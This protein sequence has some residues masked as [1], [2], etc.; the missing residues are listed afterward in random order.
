MEQ[1][2]VPAG[3]MRERIAAAV[4]TT[5]LLTCRIH[6]RAMRTPCTALANQAPLFPGKW[7]CSVDPRAELKSC[8]TPSTAKVPSRT[9]FVRRVAGNGLSRLAFGA[10]GLDVR[11]QLPAIEIGCSIRIDP[12]AVSALI[13]RKVSCG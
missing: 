1:N 10:S 3:V 5:G 9:E 7:E 2:V 4:V 12:R 6:V 13:E 8:R 11:G